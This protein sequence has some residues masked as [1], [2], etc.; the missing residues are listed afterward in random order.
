MRA[1]VGIWDTK[2]T[3]MARSLGR[4]ESGTRVPGVDIVPSVMVKIRM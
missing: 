4:A 1:V 2:Y 3:N